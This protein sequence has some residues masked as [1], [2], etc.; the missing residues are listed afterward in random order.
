MK[1]HFGIFLF[2][3]AFVMASCTSFRGV[4]PLYPEPGHPASPPK[5]ESLQPTFRWEPS[6]DSGVSYDFIIYECLKVSDFWKGTSRSVG[7][8]I[9][10]R[11]G[12]NSTEH[13]IEET[14][15]PD[16]EYYWS[17]RTRQGE[18]VSPWALYNYTLFLGTAYTKATNQPFL[19]KTPDR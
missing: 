6:S 12:L 7:R 17:I 8:E 3:L 18:T 10:Y 1:K 19:F 16:S 4:K 14:L 9:Y 2:L 11:Q 15:K 13:K 5:V